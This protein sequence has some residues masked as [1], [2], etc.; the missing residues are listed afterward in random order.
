VDDKDFGGDLPIFGFAH[1]HPCGTDVSSG[2]LKVFPAMKL[3]EG[4]WKM[5]EYAVTPTGRPARD[6]RGQLI[7]A[8]GWLATGDLDAPR[9]YKWNF[10]GEVFRW[11]EE[12]GQWEFQATC[13]PQQPDPRTGMPR[14]P[15]CS[16][17]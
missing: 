8:W 14:L 5:I 2:D 13:T 12:K 16:P 9:F 6:A 4:H 17:K 7:P 1:N 3:S 15:K 11:R 10:A